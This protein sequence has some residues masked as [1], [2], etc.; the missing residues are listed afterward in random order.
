MNQTEIFKL[1]EWLTN[2][3]KTGYKFKP[4]VIKKFNINWFNYIN[5]FMS[6][7][8]LSFIQSIYHI[9]NSLT[10]VPTCEMEFPYKFN[11]FKLGYT[12][13]CVE[14]CKSC[15][16]KVYDQ[17]QKNNIKKWGVSNPMQ[18][19]QVKEKQ[20]SNNLK[21]WGVKNQFQIEEVKEKIKNTTFEKWGVNH[22]TKVQEIKEKKENTNLKK[23]GVKHSIQNPTVK[24]KAKET[25]LKNWGYECPLSSPAIQE[26]IKKTNIETRGVDHVMKDPAVRENAKNT[27]IKKYGSKTWAESDAAIEHTFKKLKTKYPEIKEYHHSTKE[28][29][30]ECKSCICGKGK[31][32]TSVRLFRQ[33]INVNG[34]H[35]C[36]NM[37]PI[38]TGI[39][40]YHEDIMK[41]IKSIGDFKIEQN[42]RNI[43][44]GKEIDIYLPDYNFGIEFNGVYWHSELY[45]EKEYHQQKSILANERGISLFHIWEDDWL[46]KPH[47][48]KSMIMNKL[49]VSKKIG[50]RKC[51]IKE[52][53]LTEANKFLDENHL[54]GKVNS[55]VRVGLFFKDEL[56][57]LMTLGKLRRV[58]NQSNI[59]N[60]WELYRFASK[61]NTNVQGG[62]TRLLNWFINNHSPNKIHTY[63]SLDHSNGGVYIKSGFTLDH[64]STPGYWWVVDGIKHHRYN[65]RKSIL[66]KEGADADKSETQIMHDRGY[67]RI[68]NSGNLKFTL[69]I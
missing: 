21:K 31:Y 55:S 40:T 65:F 17:I 66:V 22:H 1:N 2:E 7:Y 53:S 58:V 26:K 52:V 63:A 4:N 10:N 56:I 34:I 44:S 6:K 15:K 59:H 8:E 51:Q 12:T 19:N 5:E 41:W 32:R 25:N 43:L 29:S 64:I 61:L 27:N 16:S 62:F 54:Q 48:V 46:I 50:G 60:E 57:A 47:I 24:E 18:L 36:I 45:K 30:V 9:I 11:N 38:K 33:R 69:N 37:N 39:S 68:W 14:Q 23:Y 42:N 67:W 13:M 28:I 49:G 3:N 20:V 35:P